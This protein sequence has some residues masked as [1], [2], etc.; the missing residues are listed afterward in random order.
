M[1]NKLAKKN[2]SCL[3]ETSRFTKA[4]AGSNSGKLM[5]GLKWIFYLKL[6]WEHIKQFIHN[7]SKFHLVFVKT[8]KKECL[9]TNFQVISR[10]VKK[11]PKYHAALLECIISSSN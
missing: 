8:N 7:Y 2:K 11:C 9:E 5:V 10:I 4:D 1:I 3:I 6:V